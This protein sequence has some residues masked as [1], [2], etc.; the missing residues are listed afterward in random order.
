ML[1]IQEML[2]LKD[3]WAEQHNSF[4]TPTLRPTRSSQASLRKTMLSAH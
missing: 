1:E 4:P 3:L 2:H